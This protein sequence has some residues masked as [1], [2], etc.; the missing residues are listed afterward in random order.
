MATDNIQS[1]SMLWRYIYAITTNSIQLSFERPWMSLE[2]YIFV[3]Y[4]TDIDACFKG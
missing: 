4:R 3:D 2:K 1:G